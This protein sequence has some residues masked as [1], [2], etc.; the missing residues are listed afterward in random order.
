MKRIIKTPNL[1]IKT[2]KCPHC[3]CEFTYTKADVD[4][5]GEFSCPHCYN[6]IKAK[7][8]I[9]Q[10]EL[11]YIIGMSIMGIAIFIT[12]LYFLS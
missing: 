9:G 5:Y 7:G 10:A 4:T 6:L 8:I 11:F 1:P 3:G 2:M 12:L